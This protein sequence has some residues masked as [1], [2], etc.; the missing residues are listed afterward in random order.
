MV[1]LKRV[2]LEESV[3]GDC[4]LIR[5]G[6][7]V[8]VDGTVA[9]G[10]AILNQSALTGEAIPVQQRSGDEVMSGSTNVGEGFYLM[11][12]HHAAESTYAGMIRLVEEAQRSK[13]PMSRLADRFALLF[14]AVTVLIS[15]VAWY[16]TGNPIR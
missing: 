5:Q 4:L 3:P 7:V 1:C 10:V 15:G 6:D 14:L 11:A 12:S 8:P 16:W 9:S 13:A 2:G